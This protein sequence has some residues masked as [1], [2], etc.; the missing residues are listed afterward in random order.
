MSITPIGT[1]PPQQ[2]K[3]KGRVAL[4]TGAGS[5]IGASIAE[6]LAGDGFAVAVVDTDGQRAAGVATQV[7]QHGTDVIWVAGDI[8]EPTSIGRTLDDVE[9]RLGQVDVL[10]NNAGWDSRASFLET[11]ES[12][13][14]ETIDINLVGA[15]RM[16]HAVLPSML[17]RSW[18]RI[19]NIAAES[20]RVG[21]ADE[22]VYSAAKGG[23]IAFSKSLALEV[24]KNGVTVNV[25]SPGPTAT[26]MLDQLISQ[27]ESAAAMISK[28][29]GS[30]P[31]GR[32]GQPRDIAPAV[33]FFASE[34]AGF[35]TGQTLS[36][37]G[38][39][40]MA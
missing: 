8:T 31:M 15:I 14:R 29:S 33:S 38:G 22:A 35:I 17:N 24:V 11:D 26:P 5:G 27:A 37:S 36:V 7:A 23:L 32:L 16:T 6:E 1:Q 18:G 10:V 20:G 2:S 28:I 25:V 34:G 39:S 19:I 30:V 3:P 12:F 9:R 21:G 4:V 40:T 13:W